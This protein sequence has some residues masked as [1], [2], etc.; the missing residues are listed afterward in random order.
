MENPY[1]CDVPKPI[2]PSVNKQTT[3]E[4]I[5]K[6]AVQYPSLAIFTASGCGT[7]DIAPN[8]SIYSKTKLNHL[9]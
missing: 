1:F 2:T 9:H 6:E 8:Y 3:Q 7:D 4:A 5:L